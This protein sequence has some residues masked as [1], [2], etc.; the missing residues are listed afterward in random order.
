MGLPHCVYRGGRFL[1]KA[2]CDLCSPSLGEV[3][4]GCVAQSLG[5]GTPFLLLPAPA[6]CPSPC[7]FLPL[8]TVPLPLWVAALRIARVAEDILSDSVVLC[9]QTT[10]LLTT[11]A[12]DRVGSPTQSLQMPVKEDLWRLKDPICATSKEHSCCLQLNMSSDGKLTP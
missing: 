9:E 2:E 4:P 8:P 3:W 6:H 5:P 11:N 12:S 1:L 7:C 10:V